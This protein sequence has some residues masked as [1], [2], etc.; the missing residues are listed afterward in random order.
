[1]APS[2]CH[3]VQNYR[4]IRIYRVRTAIP[5]PLSPYFG[6][7]GRKDPTNLAWVLDGRGCYS[8]SPCMTWALRS[9]CQQW[10]ACSDRVTRSR[11]QAWLSSSQTFRYYDCLLCPI[12]ILLV[13]DA[14]H[15]ARDARTNAEGPWDMHL[16]YEP[17]TDTT[18]RIY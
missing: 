9:V 3:C 11:P 14:F 10:N 6:N 13:R 5:F 7:M 18:S 8:T 12:P 15:H 16:I 4:A 1:M 17:T 2:A